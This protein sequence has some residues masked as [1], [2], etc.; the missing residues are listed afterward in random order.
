LAP[1]AQAGQGQR[2][3]LTAGDDQVHLWWQV[4]E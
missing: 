1:D 2:R 4:L 3:I